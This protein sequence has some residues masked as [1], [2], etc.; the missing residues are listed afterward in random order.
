MGTG[1][2]PVLW[3]SMIVLFIPGD[4]R[5]YSTSVI[6][7]IPLAAN[8]YSSYSCGTK[9]KVQYIFHYHTC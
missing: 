5:V 7:D 9:S 1:C 8:F 6:Y 4:P 3:N 2:L